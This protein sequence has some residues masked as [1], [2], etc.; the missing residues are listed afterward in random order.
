MPSSNVI[1]GFFPHGLPQFDKRSGHGIAQA[2]TE[3]PQWVRDAVAQRGPVQMKA[4]PGRPAAPPPPQPQRNASAVPVPQPV[5]AAHGG[6]GQVIV[7]EVRQMMEA[8]FHASF[9]DVRVHVGP[10]APAIGA[11]AFTRGSDIHFA[12]GHYNPQTP[13]GR[14][15]LAHELTHVVQQRAGRVRSPIANGVSIVQDHALEAEAERMAMRAATSRIVQRS[16]AFTFGGKGG[17]G[18]GGDPPED[19]SRKIKGAETAAIRKFCNDDAF[20]EELLAAM[21]AFSSARSIRSE[22]DENGARV[23]DIALLRDSPF[24]AVINYLSQSL[25]RA[26]GR[27]DHKNEEDI[28]PA[29]RYAEYGI[30][31]GGMRLV[32]NLDDCSAYVSVHYKRTTVYRLGGAGIDALMARLI[33]NSAD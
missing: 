25:V 11:L 16:K 13:R 30:L 21:Y 24:N 19:M 26:G 15:I 8:L 22:V 29:G 2:K 7:P 3:R 12:P 33:N 1:Q 9:A 18:K 31:G 14:Q 27:G 23:L 28:Y 6:P 20:M 32:V 17:S 4:Q 10:Q 5:L